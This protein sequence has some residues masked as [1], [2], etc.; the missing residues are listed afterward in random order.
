MM[1]FFLSR[2]LFVSTTI[3]WVSGNDEKRKF[4][5][6]RFE[7][8]LPAERIC[9]SRSTEFEYRIRQATRGRGVDVVLNS[10]SEEKLQ[11]RRPYTRSEQ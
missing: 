8:Q 10:L 9:N 7:G 4:L 1:G 2:L 3:S 5:L 11:V 6:E